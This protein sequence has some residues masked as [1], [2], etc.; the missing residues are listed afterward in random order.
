MEKPQELVSIIVPVYNAGLYI[1]ETIAM[2]QAQTYR[3]WELILVDDHSSD[4]GRDRI[5]RC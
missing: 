3:N 2:V 5:E 4:D 1:E